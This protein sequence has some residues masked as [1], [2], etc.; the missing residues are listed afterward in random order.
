MRWCLV[1]VAT[2]A[3]ILFAPCRSLAVA[4]SVDASGMPLPGL[5]SVA[6]VPG[7]SALDGKYAQRVGGEEGI[8]AGKINAALR[9]LDAFPSYSRNTSAL[10]PY[11]YRFDAND[12][13]AA[14]L[15]SAA[16]TEKL[17]EAID[18]SLAEKRQVPALSPGSVPP[19]P[20]T[21]SGAQFGAEM[22]KR[23]SQGPFTGRVGSWSELGNWVGYQ[24]A[25]DLE[26][27]DTRKVDFD[28]SYWARGPHADLGGFGAE[29]SQWQPKKITATHAAQIPMPHALV[30][31]TD[32]I[33]GKEPTGL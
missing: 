11:S 2:T 12:T 10:R 22:G 13:R 16:M 7:S 4:P 25:K 24:A 31:R 23:I 29:K 6:N 9:A 30:T 18:Q 20:S 5:D 27:G 32:H 21:M 19:N 8:S 14:S 28:A 17:D 26:G 3:S 15:R 33:S 1:H